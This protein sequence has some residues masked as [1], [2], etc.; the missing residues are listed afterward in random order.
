MKKNDFINS[1]SKT[2]ITCY[3]ELVEMH[4]LQF[5][6][7]DYLHINFVLLIYFDFLAFIP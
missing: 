7:N 5:S 3:I 1:I 4:C 2:R 6:Y